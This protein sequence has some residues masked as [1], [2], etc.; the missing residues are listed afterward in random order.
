M[1]IIWT[2]TTQTENR[3]TAIK[4]QTASISATKRN[5]KL[6]LINNCSICYII[7]LILY[8]RNKMPEKKSNCFSSSSSSSSKNT[9]L[10]T[11]GVK[12]DIFKIKTQFWAF[13]TIAIQ[14]LLVV[15]GNQDYLTFNYGFLW[16]PLGI[17][18][19][20]LFTES[21]RKPKSVPNLVWKPEDGS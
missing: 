21:L 15:L 5:N 19:P 17:Q 20:F 8:G 16:H 10:D 6:V 1:D 2:P 11:E 4:T 18:H 3:P 12:M 13:D 7:Y 14:L 9:F